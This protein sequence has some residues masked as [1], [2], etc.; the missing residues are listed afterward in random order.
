MYV[1]QFVLSF[2][3]CFL[4]T[5]IVFSAVN[6]SIETSL[7]SAGNAE[8]QWTGHRRAH[9]WVHIVTLMPALDTTDLDSINLVFGER[10]GNR[11]WSRTAATRL[12]R[13]ALE[14][15]QGGISY[16]ERAGCL[17]TTRPLGR[18]QVASHRANL[19]RF[20]YTHTP[21]HFLANTAPIL[22]YINGKLLCCKCNLQCKTCK[23]AMF[24]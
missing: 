9:W 19:Q 4:I 20:S 3:S 15:W 18:S 21:P 22:C 23:N 8:E 13:L 14:Y 6:A 11:P 16:L 5:S 12:V 2:Y 24:P 10:F 17:D 1:R 7:A